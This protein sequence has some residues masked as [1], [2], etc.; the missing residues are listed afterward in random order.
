M[1][2]KHI[3]LV[4]GL[5]VAALIGCGV[6][7]VESAQ[8]SSSHVQAN[9][10]VNGRDVKRV[11]E[12]PD[13]RDRKKTAEP[14][15]GNQDEQPT[16]TAQGGFENSLEKAR[17]SALA[18]AK[19]KFREYLMGQDDPIDREPGT[20]MV[21]RMLM[22]AQEQIQEESIKSPTSSGTETMYRVTVAVKVERE[23]LRTM[24]TRD[25][26]CEALGLIGIAA[27]ILLVTAGFFRLDAMTK[28][29]VT[30]WL[31][32]GTVGAGAMLLGLWGYAW[33]W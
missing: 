12:I 19:D 2:C 3:L 15:K 27:V 28:G 7:S 6:R 10:T 25:R 32:L 11:V 20:E 23:H 17:Q 5:V 13:G 14:V 26:S 9:V 31:L 18:A 33:P 29:Y 22:P 1:R 16:F 21:R 30:T 8:S 4:I 24:R